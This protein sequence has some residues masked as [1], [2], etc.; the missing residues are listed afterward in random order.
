MGVHFKGWGVDAAGNP[1]DFFHPFTGGVQVGGRNPAA[2]LLA[3]GVPEGVGLDPQLGNVIGHGVEAAKRYKS[4][5]RHDNGPFDGVLGYAYHFDAGLFA[6]FLQEVATAR[7]ALH[8]HHIVADMLDAARGHIGA[9]QLRDGGRHDVELVIDCSG[10]KGLLI[11]E[12]LE[13]PFVSFADYL[14]NDS[15]IAMQIA[16]EEVPDLYPATVTTA[17]DSGW[18]W[19]IP[20]QSR[21]G[22]GHVF[23]KAFQSAD[24]AADA[25]V[26][27]YPGA[28]LVTQPREVPMR[29]GR[30]R[31]SWVGNC[32]A[33]GLAS[34]F[35][36]PLESTSIQFVDYAC[37]RLLQF[38]PTAEFEPEPIAKFNGEIE[39]AYNEVRDFLGLHFT[40]GNREDTPYW[41]AM[42][43]E[44]KRSDE[45]ENCLALWRRALP[46]IYD[47]RPS[48][49]FTFW[50]VT[51]V[52]F[53]KG[54]YSV[55]LATGT[56]LLPL[57]VWERYCKEMAGLR[58]PLM[59]AMPDHG[60][61]LRA[62]SAS[63]VI[64]GSAARQAATRAVPFLGNALGPS[65]PVMTPGRMVA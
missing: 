50:S 1:T 24:Q 57:G 58:G 42:R 7:I 27:A 17:M 35:L 14:I 64:G 13:E 54:F 9:L 40:L 55:P 30:C 18:S 23:C 43:H 39:A 10:F 29:V 32:V 41:R 15:A 11:N 2:S 61:M 52:L 33:I 21:V 4:P 46:D 56:D 5:K 59:D 12:A 53:G 65:I 48:T 20:L 37:R 62:M 31:R 60:E 19:R 47:P 44:V 16:H 51:C 25:L 38:L 8:A 28:E 6:G 22:T 36:E 45:L 34:G 49:L 26:A 63:A 3:Y